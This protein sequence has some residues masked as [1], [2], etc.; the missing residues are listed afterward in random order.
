MPILPRVCGYEITRPEWLRDQAI[1]MADGGVPD[2]CNPASK[3]FTTAPG[4][5]EERVTV[6]GGADA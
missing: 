4:Q 5:P 3:I 6:D 2:L 1:Q